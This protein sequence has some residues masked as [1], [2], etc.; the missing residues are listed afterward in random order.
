MPDFQSVNVGSIPAGR[1]RLYSLTVRTPNFDFGN[2]SSILGGAKRILSDAF[3][4]F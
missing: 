1:I 2:P 3:L 4:L